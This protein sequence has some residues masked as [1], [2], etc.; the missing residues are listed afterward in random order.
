LST[1]SKAVL[2]V[3]TFSPNSP[4]GQLLT[5]DSNPT[6]FTKKKEKKEKRIV[7]KYI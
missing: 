5:P 7:A 3:M 4:S 6:G 2:L 1:R